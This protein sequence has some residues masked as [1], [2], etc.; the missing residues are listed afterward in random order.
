M[1]SDMYP[2]CSDYDCYNII[3]NTHID[4]RL[5]YCL[6]N[7]GNILLSQKIINLPNILLKMLWGKA[8]FLIYKNV[9]VSNVTK[10]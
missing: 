6:G 7:I 5:R 4:N 3:N 10:R 8:R 9:D 1:Q 2:K